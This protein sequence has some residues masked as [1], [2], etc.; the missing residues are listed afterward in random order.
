M[1]S[2]LISDSHLSRRA[3]A[4]EA[5][6]RRRRE[7][8]KTRRALK[9]ELHVIA[10][11]SPMPSHAAPKLASRLRVAPKALA[12]AF[13]TSGCRCLGESAGISPDAQAMQPPNQLRVFVS[14]RLRV[15]PK[16]QP[17]AFVTSGSPLITRNGCRSPASVHDKWLPVSQEKPP[18]QAPLLKPCSP[19]ISFVSSSLRVFA[20]RRRRKRKRS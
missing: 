17:Q 7:D 15:A 18:A 5:R 20:S 6:A 13:V 1:R 12:Q 2:E 11:I 19:Q 14:S 16:A 4:R 3:D 10:V 9:E 8:S